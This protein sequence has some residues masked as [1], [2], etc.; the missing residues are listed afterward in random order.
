VI[1]GSSLGWLIVFFGVTAIPDGLW[2]VLFVGAWLGLPTAI[3]LDTRT[4]AVYYEWPKYRWL[5]L[6]G[7]LV[8]FVAV[9]PALIYL[10]RR[11]SVFD[12]AN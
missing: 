10:W 9:I 1:L 8:W 6:V 3:Y 4:I 11:R 7:S 12:A 2:A 5:Y